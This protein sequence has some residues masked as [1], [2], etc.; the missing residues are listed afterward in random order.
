MG[1]TKQKLL[2]VLV[3]SLIAL[4]LPATS[5]SFAAPGD[6]VQAPKMAVTKESLQSR[7]A[8]LERLIKTS[9]G[10]QQI[11][12]G[13]N[14]EAK[15]M[16][17][18]ALGLYTQGEEQ[19]RSG[20]YEQANELF[21]LATREMF[22]AVRA[23]GMPEA[24]LR[25]KENDFKAR[26]ESVEALLSALTRVAEEKKANEQ[27]N[28]V[29]A[30]VRGQVGDAR[31]LADGGKIDEARKLVDNAYE[32]TKKSLESLRGGDTLVRSLNFASK[33]EE[34]HYELD[35]N[36]THQMLVKV[37]LE[38]KMK[39]EYIKNMVSKFLDKAASLRSDAE[40]A[41]GNKEFAQAVELL[42][43]ATKQLVR[44]IRGAGVYIPG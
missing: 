30:A 15:A 9:S 19:F 34:Y 10:A 42:E 23:M 27:I 3:A 37:L 1:N 29:V 6:A 36:D 38:E 24:S 2:P 21:N 5:P 44:A 7:M 12:N 14:D 31:A 13:S 40:A 17:E 20:R 32:E 28:P 22:S 43:E 4:A 33:E 8:N 16:R 11:L 35:R 18:K 26:A 39:T 25:K 41:A